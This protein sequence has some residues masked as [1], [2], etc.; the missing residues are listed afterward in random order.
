MVVKTTSGSS[1]EK[2]FGY[3]THKQVLTGQLL[4]VRTEER[5]SEKK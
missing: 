1:L 2:Q 4:P 3:P 5:A